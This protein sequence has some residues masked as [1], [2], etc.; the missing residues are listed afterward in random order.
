M[1]KSKRTF[2][3]EE[4]SN[5]FIPYL[6]SIGFERPEHSVKADGR[7]AF[8][9]GSLVR[10]HGTAQDIIEIQFDKYSKPKFIINFRRDPPEFAKE[11]RSKSG[12]HKWAEAEAFRLHPRPKSTGW[13]TM[14]TFFGLRS[15]ETS[16][17]EVV[18]QLMNVFPEVESWFNDREM[19]QHLRFCPYVII[20]QC[21]RQDGS[22]S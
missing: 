10:K 7:S 15:P 8:P 18:D 19:G 1:P 12:S 13:F 16:A 21:N 20:S 11:R 14:R 17:K 5:R 22:A 4:L 9:F 3:R 2:L 6:R